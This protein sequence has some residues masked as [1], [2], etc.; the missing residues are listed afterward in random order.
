MLHVLKVLKSKNFTISEL[1]YG[2]DLN[3]HVHTLF[4]DRCHYTYFLKRNLQ[5]Q[6]W[7]HGAEGWGAGHDGELD[8]M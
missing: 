4:A 8:S 2:L 1:H 7:D 3:G 5:L 6:R